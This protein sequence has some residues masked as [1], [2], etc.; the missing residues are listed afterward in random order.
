VTEEVFRMPE[1]LQVTKLCRATIYNHVKAGLFPKPIK[2][3]GRASGWLKSEVM[4][5]I[6]ARKAERDA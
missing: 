3:N 4:S 1:V 2:L 5:W 6:E